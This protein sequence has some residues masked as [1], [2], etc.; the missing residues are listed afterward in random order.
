MPE[1]TIY[2]V[3]NVTVPEENENSFPIML[4]AKRVA[5]EV[6]SLYIY[7]LL[8]SVHNPSLCIVHFCA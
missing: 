4:C 7:P 2:Q 1:G 8:I 5:I 3:G 6:G